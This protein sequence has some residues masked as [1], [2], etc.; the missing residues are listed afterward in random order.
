VTRGAVIVGGSVAGT[1]VARGLRA[2]GFPHPVTILEAESHLPYDKPPLSKA[3][4]SGPEVSPVPLLTAAEVGD[5][6]IDLQLGTRAVHLDLETAVVHTADGKDVPFREL[7]I[8]TGASAKPSPW[9][10][11]T[12]VHVLRTLDDAMAVRHSLDRGGDVTIIGAGFIGSEIAS[13]ARVRGLRVTMVDP[14]A[15][16]MT[17]IVGEKLGQR[18]VDLHRRH[19]VDTRFG[20]G[21]ETIEQDGQGLLVHLDDG[22]VLRSATVIVGIGTVLNTR[23][24]DGSGLV[25]ED[26]VVCDDFCR[27]VGQLRVHAVGDTARWY[28]RRHSQ[29]ARTEH[30]TNAIEQAACVA[31]NITHPDELRA[32]EPIE[33][34]WSD[35]YD[36]KVHILGRPDPLDQPTL[37]EDR[38]ADRLA[39]FW[40]SPRDEIT[41]AI[42]VNWSKASVMLRRAIATRA[43]ASGLVHKLVPVQR[44]AT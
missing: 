11:P 28:H 14:V 22:S 31:W 24:L 30:W 41:G 27:A 44:I 5:L 36:W 15:V 12:G 10:A 38:D 7:I 3:S 42:T 8:A 32:Y 37:I 19:G 23:W 35:Q 13:A 6:D 20:V 29:S 21:V 18:F 40:T 16:P 39:A 43:A 26:G 33:Y 2:N 4:L 1:R 34:V 25:I 9:G 17:R